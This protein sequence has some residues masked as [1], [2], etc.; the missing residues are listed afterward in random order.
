MGPRDIELNTKE[1][2]STFLHELKCVC[3]ILLVKEY[4]VNSAQPANHQPSFTYLSAGPG[5]T[6]GNVPKK[7]PGSYKGFSPTLES[8]LFSISYVTLPQIG[9]FLAG[10]K[11]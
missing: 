9:V 7:I 4:T 6:I 5:S 2:S 8:T 3:F 1:V 11:M 10:K